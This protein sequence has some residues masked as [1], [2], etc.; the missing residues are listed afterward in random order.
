MDTQSIEKPKRP[1]SS[2]MK[3]LKEFNTSKGGSWSIPK[4]DS[5]EY[6]EVKKIMERLSTTKQPT[7]EKASEVKTAPKRTKKTKPQS[8]AQS[9]AQSK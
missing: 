3:A 1:P 4:K 9:E 7:P 5:E 2:W 6:L 8:E